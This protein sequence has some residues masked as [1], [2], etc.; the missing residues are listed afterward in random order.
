MTYLSID[1]MKLKH[2]GQEPNIRHLLSEP[3]YGQTGD[4]FHMLASGWVR[5]LIKD[6][7][8]GSGFGYLSYN[9]HQLYSICLF[10]GIP[11]KPFTFINK[12]PKH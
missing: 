6:L 3:K 12:R 4:I 2:K 9:P 7:L 5:H 10:L 1:Y 11:L 8:G